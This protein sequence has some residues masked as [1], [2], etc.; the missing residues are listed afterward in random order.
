MKNE[1]AVQEFERVE[2]QLHS[3]LAE[4]S[5]LSKKKANDGLNKFKLK[6]VNV[7]LDRM[8]TILGAQKPF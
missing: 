2:Q 1:A 8:N 4:M 5:E 6:L 3:M 7:L